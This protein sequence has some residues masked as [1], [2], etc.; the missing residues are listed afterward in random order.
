[1]SDYSGISFQEL[2]ELPISIFLLLKK[3]SWIHSMQQSE[4]S[5]EVLKNIQRLNR[6]KADKDVKRKSR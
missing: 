6:T 3:D 4:E 5:I 2:E 1:M